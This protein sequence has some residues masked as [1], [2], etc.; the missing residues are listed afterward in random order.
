VT[1][2]S[3]ATPPA[4]TG[5]EAWN[6]A[7]ADL[8]RRCRHAQPDELPG[9]VNSCCGP[10]GVTVTLYLVD[11]EHGRLWPV[12]EEG[13]ATPRSVAV[14]GT[15]GGHAFTTVSTQRTVDRRGTV[16]LWV[17]MADGAE[18]LGVAE[19]SGRPGPGRLE[20]LQRHAETA[21]ALTAQLLTGRMAHGDMFHRT[22]RTRTMPPA[23]ELL[24]S[25]VPP[26]TFRCRR[27]QITTMLEPSYDVGGDAFDYAVDGT[28][29]YFMILDS[30]GRGMQAALTSAAV[31]AATRAARRAGRGL[32]DMARAAD[33]MLAE[34]FGNLRFAT[35]VL[36]RLDT[37]TGRMR[38]LN[39]G[40]P[41]P[42][43]LRPGQPVRTLYHG[44]RMPLGLNDNPILLGVEQ[45]EPGDRLLLYTDGVT[46][47]R[48]REQPGSGAA[49][50]A[51][52]ARWSLGPDL[53]GPDL[54]GPDLTGPDLTGPEALRRLAQAVIRRGGPHKVDDATLMLLEWPPNSA[55]SL[56]HPA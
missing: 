51:D 50:L 48:D 34:Q 24:L 3:R 46:D 31:L 12:P 21:V 9:L 11:H 15:P 40:H 25:L 6:A 47:P 45:L 52:A 55:E 44:R 23:A 30:M 5:E 53:T 19:V 43:L 35:G 14:Q 13:R 10:L 38:Y 7:L 39:A 18:R 29:A 49:W 28:T 2:S 27:L 1:G 17:P 36:A 32:A 22:R 56:D 8:V 20:D 26:L 37:V 41:A 16:C 42:V 33:V 54:T 4:D